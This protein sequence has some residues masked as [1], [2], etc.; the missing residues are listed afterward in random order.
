M[1]RLSAYELEKRVD[2]LF[3]ELPGASVQYDK[4]RNET[5]ISFFL[6][7]N[8][9]ACQEVLIL[10]GAQK[11]NFTCDKGREETKKFVRTRL[12]SPKSTGPTEAF[13]AEWFIEDGTLVIESSLRTK[14][15][16]RLLAHLLYQAILRFKRTF[17][18]I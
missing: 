7:Q 11:H 14:V 17:P 9:V 12:L 13:D 5:S 18:V 8:R 3:Q 15:R 2:R 1:A 16:T 6:T 10:W 4:R